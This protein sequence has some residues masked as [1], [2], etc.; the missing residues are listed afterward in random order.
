MG[1]GDGSDDTCLYF[2]CWASQKFR[3][4]LDNL[5]RSC[6]KLK[7]KREGRYVDE[8]EPWVQ[9]SLPALVLALAKELGA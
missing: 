2:S 8:W 6:P 7:V 4:S 9:P 3:A 5:V 1:W